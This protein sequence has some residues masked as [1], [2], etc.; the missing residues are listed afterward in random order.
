MQNPTFNFNVNFRNNDCFSHFYL[1]CPQMNP[2]RSC[3]L[4][5]V[6]PNNTIILFLVKSASVCGGQQD[7]PRQVSHLTW[8]MGGMGVHVLESGSYFSPLSRTVLFSSAP[9][10]TNRKPSNRAE[11][12]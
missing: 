4:V 12:C 5:A 2:S 7:K 9:P 1:L 3:P 10:M 11:P 8:S 6:T